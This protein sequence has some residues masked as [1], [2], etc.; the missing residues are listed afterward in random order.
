MKPP[1]PVHDIPEEEKREVKII[2]LSSSTLND[3]T[4][5]H[6]HQY[7]ECFV[8]LKGGGTHVIDFVE[9]PIHSHSIH[10]VTPG[11]VHEVKRRQ[12]S[13]GYVYLFELILFD[14][15][16][17]IEN[18]LFDHTCFDVKEFS[19]SYR[20]PAAFSDQL[21]NITR[22]IW[23]EYNAN[24]E[25][26]NHFIINQLSLLILHC[27]RNK[28]S[29][30]AGGGDIKHDTDYTAFRRM[31]NANFKNIKKVKDYA[32]AL[33]ITEKHLNEIVMQR[34]GETAS[35]FIHKQTILEAKRLLN[36]GM[37]AKE[38][39]YEL[40]FMDPAH[41]SKFFKSQT[42]LSPSAFRAD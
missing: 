42:G 2:E 7:F 14:N 18:F 40:N 26:K 25:F 24:D 29:S 10:I 5:P 1:I 12:G 3:S 21:E 33:R 36:T 38:V 41:F 30:P 4:G 27:M 34:T 16:K 39:A 28:I 17:N 37:P 35:T 19:P 6:R 15:A 20:F 31:L 13:Y 32:T 9:F 23:A 8:F 11:Q 22:Q